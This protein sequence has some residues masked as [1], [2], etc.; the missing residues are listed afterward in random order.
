MQ[1]PGF[2]SRW[3]RPSQG[4][5]NGG[6]ISK[7]PRCR[8]DV[9]HNQPNNQLSF[10]PFLS[11]SLPLSPLLS[12]SRLPSLLS[13]FLSPSLFPP[14][15]S[16]TLFLY[17]FSYIFL[18][19]L[20]LSLCSPSL[21]L[22]SLSFLHS[23]NLS[24]FSLSLLLS[25]FFLRLDLP[26]SLCLSVSISLSAWTL[27]SLVTTI[28]HVISLCLSVFVSFSLDTEVLSR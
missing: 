15:L 23:L 13:L 24:S 7:W 8:W 21:S 4:T 6:A 17:L 18:R 19:S 3:E 11:S 25:I 9:K 2:D 26:T 22:F 10:S 1:R 28:K 16:P 14:P 5:V 27:R 20:S 12:P